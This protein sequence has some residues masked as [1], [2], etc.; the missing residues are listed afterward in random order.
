MSS[1][2]FDFS[3]DLPADLADAVRKSFSEP[4]AISLSPSQSKVSLSQTDDNHSPIGTP[5][6]S[7]INLA[8]MTNPNEILPLSNYD[9]NS[10]QHMNRRTH[11][12]DTFSQADVL[13][14]ASKEVNTQE[15][16][17]QQQYSDYQLFKH[18]YSISENARESITDILHDLDIKSGD[19]ISPQ[20]FSI[21]STNIVSGDSIMFSQQQQQQQQQQLPQQYP[22]EV[23]SQQERFQKQLR[24]PFIEKT[25][26]KNTSSKDMMKEKF[27]NDYH[28]N[29]EKTTL[30]TDT[31]GITMSENKSNIV[32]QMTTRRSSIQ[33][34]QWIRQLLNPR[35]SFSGP[36]QTTISVNDSFSERY[37]LNTTSS[38]CDAFPRMGRAT[39]CWVTIL[40]D[41]SIEFVKSMIVLYHS[42]L[43][44]NS[45]YPMYVLHDSNVDVSELEKYNVYTVPIPKQYFQNDPNSINETLLTSAKYRTLLEKRWYILS[46]FVSFINT[47]YELI[48]YIT[49]TSMVIDNIDELLDDSNINDE[50]DNETCVLLSNVTLKDS[51]E[52]QLIIFKPSNDVSMCIKEY[53][54]LYGNDKESLHK[55]DKLLQMTDSQVLKELFGETWGNISSDGYVTVLELNDES[56]NIS[57]FVQKDGES[58]SRN[59]AKILDFKNVK[60]WEMDISNLNKG[61]RD[62]NNVI[63]KWYQIWQ[64]FWNTYRTR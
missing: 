20:P 45:K 64:E 17:Q 2:N 59:N 49:P 56:L 19:S 63:N 26:T 38:S 6:E 48:C 41:G 9:C 8:S 62:E 1:F 30:N 23:I 25:E 7:N 29:P 39:K 28:V 40:K 34:V 18:H 60:P 24:N 14:G 50:I 21:P 32:N 47:N 43:L 53:F 37:N 36:S 16:P 10:N 44:T 58:T 11:G 31:S 15:I 33:N 22:E 5:I 13:H 35:S 61:Q 51:E 42:L 54:T 4:H 12:T 55:M 3:E 46:L 52:P 57:N 27:D